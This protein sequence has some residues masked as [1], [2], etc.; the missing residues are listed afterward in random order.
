[1]IRTGEKSPEV[2]DDKKRKT[3]QSY[4]PDQKSIFRPGIVDGLISCFKLFS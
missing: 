2:L 1:M 4:N 3:L